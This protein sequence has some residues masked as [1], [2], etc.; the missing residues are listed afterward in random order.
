MMD[1]SRFEMDD[2][3]ISLAFKHLDYDDS[4]FIDR[5][6]I[7]K[8][9]GKDNEEVCDYIVDLVDTDKDGKI[10]FAEFKALMCQEGF[11]SKEF[12]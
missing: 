7:L 10:S 2:D 12:Q 1:H 4:G 5:D 9:F 3:K 8:L 6:E 11:E